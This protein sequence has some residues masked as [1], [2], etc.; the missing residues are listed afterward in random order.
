[1]FNSLFKK[2]LIAF[3]GIVLISAV[4]FTAISIY[5]VRKTVTW[6]MENDGRSMVSFIRQELLEQK[7][8][9]PALISEQFANLKN[10][11]NGNLVY[12]ALTDSKLNVIASSDNKAGGGADAATSA[13]ASENGAAGN[14]GG[15]DAT[16]SATAKASANVADTI[17]SAT[18]AFVS[19]SNAG[20][21][22]LNVSVPFEG[23][24][25]EGGTV[26]VGISLKALNQQ[27]SS[28]VTTIIILS[29]LV[30]IVAV[31]LG[32]LFARSLTKPIT[33]VVNKL[34]GFS[35]GDF[36]VEFHSRSKDEIRKLTDA[37]NHS[38]GTLRDM[39]LLVKR[40]GE[41]LYNI[42][43]ALNE[44]NDEIAA[45][46]VS[47]SQNIEAVSH[48]IMEQSD[49]I[50]YITQ[51]LESF[52][53]KFDGMLAE[54]TE[55]VSSNTRIKDTIEVEYKNLQQL[56]DSVKQMQQYFDGAIEEIHKLNDEV[57]KINEI[58]TIINNV[59]NQTSML[60]LN[61]S[62]ESARAGE[63]GRGF[64]VVAEEIKKLAG[65]VMG[66]SNTI[67]ELIGNVTANTLKV[68]DNTRVISG[69]MDTE[70]QV[71]DET[72]SACENIRVA[73]DETIGRI[74]EVSTSVKALAEEKQKI[75][76]KVSDVSVIS[77][78][79]AASAQEITASVQ[80]Q[81]A[82]MEEILAMSNELDIAANQL[83]KEVDAFKVEK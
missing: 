76:G 9:D 63:A 45:N 54:T 17:T 65:Q 31:L 21:S 55:V 23:G 32:L 66:Y 46:G 26:S 69:Q 11:S 38:V 15:A 60:A 51:A 2:I 39:I 27:I 14:S 48:S 18:T 20:E 73:V 81:S 52:G 7:V 42:T 47:V 57:G 22:V 68:V 13:T 1:M 28:T 80:N 59:A 50:H 70:K 44:A 34:D 12:I 37:M 58:T 62:I 78:Q 16:S 6:Q 4:L 33:S 5:E 41:K 64:A 3:A 75:I 49:N 19:E 61:A 36:T 71:I 8:T 56:V 72:V 53:S 82:G 29:L 10:A 25:L 67:N 43:T 79:V 77:A 74:G 40:I 24:F 30:L 35:K 83:K